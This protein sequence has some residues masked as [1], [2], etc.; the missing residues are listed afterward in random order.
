MFYSELLNGTKFF[1]GSTLISAY[2]GRTRT[3]EQV[4]TPVCWVKT[5]QDGLAICTNGLQTVSFDYR[6]T[7]TGNNR[8]ERDHG[9]RVYFL[10]AVH[11]YLNCAN[12]S[13]RTVDPGDAIPRGPENGF[14]S[15]FNDKEITFILPHTVS[16]NVPAGYTKK[17]GATMTQQVLASL[18]SAEQLGTRY[19]QGTL[20]VDC[21]N[22][23][24]WITNAESM[25]KT[26]DRGYINSHCGSERSAGICPLVKIKDDAPIDVTENG[27]YIIRIPE[28]DFEGDIAAFLGFELEAA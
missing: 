20:G 24:T 17:N 23:Y 2:N 16:V 9:N 6:R 15:I 8:Y 21:R 26:F 18:P 22:I 27:E 14:L 7:A 4:N 3:Y 12:S 11:K 10:S 13:W 5:A 25:S 19:E 28:P 1:F